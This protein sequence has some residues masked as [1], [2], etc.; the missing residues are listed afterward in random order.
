MPKER[1]P[2]GLFIK[3]LGDGAHAGPEP[4]AEPEL[5]KHYASNYASTMRPFLPIGVGGWVFENLKLLFLP[6]FQLLSTM[7]T[8]GDP[9]RAARIPSSMKGRDP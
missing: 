7:V 1:D 3:T 6:L 5:C 4:E 2:S 9:R 8:A